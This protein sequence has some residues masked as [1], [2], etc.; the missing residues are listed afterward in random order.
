M[1]LSLVPDAE[2]GMSY[3]VPAVTVGG[4][5]I[6]G[7]AYFAKHCGY[8]PHSG[9]VLSSIDPELLAG[10]DW[11]AGTLRFPP[12]AAPPRSLIEQLVTVRMAELDA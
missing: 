7:Y 1:L 5:P 4:T 2:E 9:D 3:G 8:Y 10:Y 12:D 6:A 11:S